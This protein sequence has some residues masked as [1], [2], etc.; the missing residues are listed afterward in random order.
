M[1]SATAEPQTANGPDYPNRKRMGLRVG[2]WISVA[3]VF[4]A[5][6]AVIFWLGN[7]PPPPPLK[8]APPPVI[9]FSGSGSEELLALQLPTEQLG[10]AFIAFMQTNRPPRYQLALES[11]L[12]A[13]GGNSPPMVSISVP[14]AL[15]VEG[16]LARLRLLTPPR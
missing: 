5:Q 3:L 15:R 10:A 1:I 4:L 11:G 8:L 12:D 14:S 16:D 9:Q 6:V 2:M 7:P 13:V